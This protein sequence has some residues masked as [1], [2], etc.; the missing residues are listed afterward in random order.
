MKRSSRLE[1]NSARAPIKED[2]QRTTTLTDNKRET[3]RTKDLQCM[4]THALASTALTDFPKCFRSLHTLLGFALFFVSSILVL[5][6]ETI[7]SILTCT[8][9]LCRDSHCENGSFEVLSLHPPSVT[10]DRRQL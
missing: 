1:P 7:Y 5:V 9:I 2:S 4:K 8:R 3:T 6:A 10:V